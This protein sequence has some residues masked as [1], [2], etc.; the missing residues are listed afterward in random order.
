MSQKKT[1]FAVVCTQ[2]QAART[3]GDVSA[4]NSISTSSAVD[5]GLSW[6]VRHCNKPHNKAVTKAQ[7]IH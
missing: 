5:N 6:S 1:V 2:R 3:L 7:S 4:V